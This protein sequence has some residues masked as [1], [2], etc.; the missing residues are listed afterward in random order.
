MKKTTEKIALTAYVITISA[1][2]ALCIVFTPQ[3]TAYTN[4]MP[5]RT[6]ECFG[7]SG[8]TPASIKLN[9]GYYNISMVMSTGDA[10]TV[11]RARPTAL[12]IK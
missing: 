11:L 6:Y 12:I 2:F 7:V 10:P 8:I 1:V 9:S 5:T 3:I 4:P